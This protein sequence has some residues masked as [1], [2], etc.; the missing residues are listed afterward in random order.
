MS[1]TTAIRNHAVLFSR[2]RPSREKREIVLTIASPR[3]LGCG[4]KISRCDDS[5]CVRIVRIELSAT[6]TVSPAVSHM[7]QIAHVDF[8]ATAFRI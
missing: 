7:S 2:I 3:Q 5:S 1:S 6:A 8:R 4:A